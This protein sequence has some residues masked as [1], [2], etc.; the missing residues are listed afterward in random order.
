MSDELYPT[1]ALG[2]S[3]R[4]FIRFIY[5]QAKDDFPSLLLDLLRNYFAV[6]APYKLVV[7]FT[8]NRD[9]STP[10]HH[11]QAHRKRTGGGLALRFCTD[12]RSDYFVDLLGLARRAARARA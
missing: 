11:R 1:S 6:S 4:D 10:I 8:G 9:V 12:P 7:N 2:C 5:H 3:H